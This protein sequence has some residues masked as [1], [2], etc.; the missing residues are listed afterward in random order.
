MILR[1]LPEARFCILQL[2]WVPKILPKPLQNEVRTPK[3]SMPKTACFLTSIFSGFGLHFG[4]S[5]ASKFEP[6]WPFWPQKTML[7]ALLSLLKIDVL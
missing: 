2:F 5:G 6:R 1:I 7:R 4:A 3:K